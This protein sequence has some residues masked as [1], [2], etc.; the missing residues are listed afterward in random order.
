MQEVGSTVSLTGNRGEQVRG[1]LVQGIKTACGVIAAGRLALRLFFFHLCETFAA[2]YRSVFSGSERN[3]CFSSASRAGSCKHFSFA[4]CCIFSCISASLASLRLVYKAFLSIKFLF[5]CCKNKF[6]ST[7]LADQCLV[8]VHFLL[9][10]L[11]LILMI[12]PWSDL[13]RHL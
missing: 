4:L 12:L 2:I 7:I 6:V 1:S 5:A 10:R 9:P 13:H 3:F 8:F 11:K